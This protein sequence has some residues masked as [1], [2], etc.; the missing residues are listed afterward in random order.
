[1][2]DKKKPSIKQIL[3]GIVAVLS[4]AGIGYGIYRLGYKNGRKSIGWIK[5]NDTWQHG[6]HFGRTVGARKVLEV[7]P[8]HCPEAYRIIMDKMKESY[9][10]RATLEKELNAFPNYL[11]YLERMEGESV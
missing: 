3:G 11:K 5:Q 7:L 2:N 6:E 1:M 10:F 9:N 8:G 4:I